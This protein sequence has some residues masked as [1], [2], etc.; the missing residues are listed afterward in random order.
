VEISNISTIFV[1]TI[2]KM[3]KLS[4]QEQSKYKQIK[5]SLL[6]WRI[7]L[8]GFTCFVLYTV[9]L[10][11]IKELT[12]RQ[13]LCVPSATL[14]CFES[15]VSAEAINLKGSTHS[16]R[17]T[18]VR[19]AKPS[20]DFIFKDFPNHYIKRSAHSPMTLVVRFIMDI[21]LQALNYIVRP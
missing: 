15:L 3:S 8:I 21:C 6:F 17:Y 19:R 4:Y 2:L 12:P 18:G 10:T 5:V 14:K 1:L 16:N 9:I 7:I 11:V 20:K 13:W